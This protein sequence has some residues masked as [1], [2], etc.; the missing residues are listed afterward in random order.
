[1]KQNKPMLQY[2]EE[3]KVYYISDL[4]VEFSITTIDGVFDRAI[5][6]FHGRYSKREW[7]V[8]KQI[9][10]MVEEIPEELYGE[11]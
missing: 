3:T 4:D 2:T 8:L 5:Y 7:A 1:M 9:A 11:V 6:P 10:E